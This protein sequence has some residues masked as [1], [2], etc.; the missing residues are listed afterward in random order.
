[1]AAA[2]GPRRETMAARSLFHS[3]KLKRSFLARRAASA[4]GL[5]P[6]RARVQEGVAGRR[7]LVRRHDAPV[8]PNFPL[9]L[10]VVEVADNHPVLVGGGPYSSARKVNDSSARARRESARP[11]VSL[12]AWRSTARSNGMPFQ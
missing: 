9:P 2:V 5:I 6:R 4:A 11:P 12:S 10:P 8:E 7:R 1:M 3:L